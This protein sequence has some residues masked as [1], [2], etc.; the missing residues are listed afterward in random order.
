MKLFLLAFDGLD[1]YLVEEWSPLLPHLRQRKWSAYQSSEEILTPYL[2]A[3]IITGLPPKEAL[4]AV[5]SVVPVNPIFRWAKKNLRFLRGLGLGKFVKRRWV[6]KSDL[7]SPAIFDVVERSI[8]IDFPAYNWHMDFEIC[9]KY[10]YSKVIGDKEKS[11]I[12]FTTVQSHDRE[13]IQMAERILMNDHSW[14]IFA[15]WIY[16]TDMVNHLYWRD[17]LKILKTYKMAD[18]F[19]ERIQKLL[20]DDCAMVIMS[21]HGGWRGVHR[22]KGFVSVNKDMELPSKT[23]DFYN[24]FLKILNE[25]G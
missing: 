2:W 10:P 21:D 3:S 14:D 4:P 9:V 17:R 8:V 25:P 18:S 7:A 24:F 11:E 16:S 5:H 1:P 23:V 22:D 15:I 12:L 20:P 6:N 13:K 19:A